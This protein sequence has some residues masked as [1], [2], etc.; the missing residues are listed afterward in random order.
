MDEDDD[1]QDTAGE[2]LLQQKAVPVHLSPYF[3][4]S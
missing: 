4:Q 2:V 1:A 3:L